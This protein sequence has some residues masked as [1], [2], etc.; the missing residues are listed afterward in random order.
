MAI[1]MFRFKKEK[2]L[3][4]NVNDFLSVSKESYSC[5]IKPKKVVG[6]KG[7]RYA[8]DTHKNSEIKKSYTVSDKTYVFCADGN[9]YRLEGG[10]MI[11]V[12]GGFLRPPNLF[13]FKYKGEEVIS[14]CGN[15]KCVMLG[16]GLQYKKIFDGKNY[17]YFAGRIF[18]SHGQKLLF[19]KLVLD[20]EEIEKEGEIDFGDE[21]RLLF[22]VDDVLYALTKT[23]I[24]K[25]TAKYSCED[26]IVTTLDTSVVDINEKS[27]T[28][29]DGKVY[30]IRSNCLTSLT[31]ENES[32]CQKGEKDYVVT[33]WASNYL[34]K[35]VVKI[36]DDI[37][38]K[39]LI[40]DVNTK[41]TYY[42]K[43]YE[44]NSCLKYIGKG[45]FMDKNGKVYLLGDGES[46]YKASGLA[47]N[48]DGKKFVYKIIVEVDADCIMTVSGDFGLKEYKLRS[49]E[50]EIKAFLNS[51]LFTIKVRGDS[52]NFGIEK[53]K[54][55]YRR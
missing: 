8:F 30:F 36:K 24:K 7:L 9:L 35:Y 27:L 40:Y 1:P 52:K 37:G 45:I 51:R 47:L 20:G 38:E 10:A 23:K 39:F 13:N 31:G 46:V 2:E 19:S 54:L 42:V 44:E 48:C 6:T 55:F 34:G 53:I 21:I 50:N 16:K 3:F 28:T 25:I 17:T 32:A 22:A 4:Y 5:L 43:P 14:V 26:F 15:G 33:D 49:G 29:I 12:S 41:D 11:L 18:C